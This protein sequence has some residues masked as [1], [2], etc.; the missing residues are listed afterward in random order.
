MMVHV[1][2]N[3]ELGWELERPLELYELHKKLIITI[4]TWSLVGIVLTAEL[5]F[6][7]AGSMATSKGSVQ[8][9][10]SVQVDGLV[11]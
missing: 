3:S 9:I 6:D 4:T 2:V 8:E 7:S 11:S 10:N 1:P 5:W